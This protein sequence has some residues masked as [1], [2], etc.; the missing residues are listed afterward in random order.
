LGLA[1]INMRSHIYH[2]SYR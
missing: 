1:H 2:N